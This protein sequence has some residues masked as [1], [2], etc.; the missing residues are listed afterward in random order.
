TMTRHLPGSIPLTARIAWNSDELQ[1]DGL[2][3]AAVP[4]GLDRIGQL[5]ALAEIRQTG[6]LDGG[7]VHENVL[8]ATLRRDET[9]ALRLIEELDGTF[10]ALVH[11]K[12]SLVPFTLS[13]DPSWPHAE[14]AGGAS[15]CAGKSSKR[16]A[17]GAE[18]DHD[19][20]HKSGPLRPLLLG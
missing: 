11:G 3:P 15:P 8:A 10:L 20:S 1:I 4:V 13:S 5:H 14:Q 2:R 16:C 7:D 18:I 17:L 9:I 12:V 19:R 6:A